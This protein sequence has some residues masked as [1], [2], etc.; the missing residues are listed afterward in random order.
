MFPPWGYGLSGSLED[1]ASR[2]AM[3]HR[4]TTM[5]AFSDLLM[6]GGLGM[7]VLAAG[8]LGC[9]L[10]MAPYRRILPA[11]SAVLP[12]TMRWRLLTSL[13]LALLSWAPILLALGILLSASRLAAHP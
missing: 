9:E 6:A 5:L 13:A 2:T 3:A 8:I 4:R 7:I 1:P 12:P 11:P 10:R